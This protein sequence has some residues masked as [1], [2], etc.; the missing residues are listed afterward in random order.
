MN[1]LVLHYA[2]VETYVEDRFIA[3]TTVGWSGG[4]QRE[5]GVDIGPSHSQ[6]HLTAMH[7]ALKSRATLLDTFLTT[8]SGA[9]KLTA[10]LTMPGGFLLALPAAW[11]FI[12]TLLDE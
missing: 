4:F 7:L 11:H 9:L 6:L 5:W 10:I 8:V 1:R 3:R 12:Q 2:Y